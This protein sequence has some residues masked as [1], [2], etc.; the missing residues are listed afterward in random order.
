MYV[1]ICLSEFVKQ[2]SR[3][4]AYD[5]SLPHGKESVVCIEISLFVSNSSLNSQLL[6]GYL[7]TVCIF[8][9]CQ[10]TIP[11]YFTVVFLGYCFVMS[12]AFT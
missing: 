10:V 5:V 9:D 7:A 8:I 12:Y 4:T 1:A 11:L 2:N 6:D 3:V